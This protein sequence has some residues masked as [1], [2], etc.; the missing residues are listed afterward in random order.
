MSQVAKDVGLSRERAAVWPGVLPV[1]LLGAAVWIGGVP[2]PASGDEAAESAPPR[3]A[4]SP[5]PPPPAPIPVAQIAPR[6]TE[7]AQLLRTVAANLVPGAEIERI[8]RSLPAVSAELTRA[9]TDTLGLLDEQPSLEALQAHDESWQRRQRRLGV[10]LAAASDR[11]TRLQ[12]DLTRL[13]EQRARWSLSRD[14]ATADGLPQSLLGQIDATLA[15][16]EAAQPLT[17]AERD[18]TLDLQARIA[19]EVVY[20]ETVRSRIGQLQQVEVG[21]LL[22]QDG[23]PLWS[24]ELWAQAHRLVP[25]RLAQIGAALGADARRY[26]SDP[27]KR[28]PVHLGIFVLALSAL[29]AG[30]RQVER[31]AEQGQRV[32][33]LVPVFD[34]PVAAAMLLALMAATNLTSPAPFAVKELLGALVLVPMILLARPVIDR[35]LRPALY[36]LG[37][38]FALD[39]LRRAFGGVPPLIGQS[40]V[41]VEVLVGVG[42]LVPLLRG[43]RAPG[44]PGRTLRGL[45][46]WLI[47]AVLAVGLVA[48]LLGYLRLAPLTA[49]A[50]LVGATDALGLYAAAEVAMAVIAYAFR[51]WPLRRLHMIDHHRERLEG[52]IF[53]LLVVLAILGW[54]VRYLSY[55]GLWEPTLAFVVGLLT[56]RF[57]MGSFGISTGAVLA[58]LATLAVALLLSSLIRFVLAEEVYPRAGISSGI[59]YAISSV[60]RYAIVA[61]AFFL[62][63]GFLGITLTQVTVLAGALGVGVGFGLQS[64]VNNFVSGLILLFERPIHVGDA[65]QVGSVQGWVRRIGIRASVVRT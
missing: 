23:R 32:S 7:V 36:A 5:F 15:A 37:F 45:L 16:I 13:A 17:R 33:R 41:L 22:A 29:L 18:Q 30:R 39:T 42:V 50:V 59:S 11:A 2:V 49:P 27:S 26:V 56:F 46:V 48:S 44:A 62:A 3:T 9:R 20:S 21:G 12:G 53:R 1:M 60:I 10:W 25:T 24:P 8:K 61:L 64:I 58:F 43:A 34:R 35:A 28:L 31:W 55:L 47:L 19:Q 63:L 54:W 40:I 6:V 38:L 65:V 51:S 4:E 14:R 52:R 57:Q